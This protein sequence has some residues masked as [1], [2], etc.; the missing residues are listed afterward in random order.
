MCDRVL[1]GLCACEC[2]LR[3]VQ[4]KVLCVLC[5]HE[6]VGVN[7]VCIKAWGVRRVSCLP[8]CSVCVGPSRIVCLL[9]VHPSSVVWQELPL[10]M[11]C[12]VGHLCVP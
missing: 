11:C 2:V 7:V 4:E 10:L 8:L 1:R 9:C 3:D 12:I 6:Y 5:V